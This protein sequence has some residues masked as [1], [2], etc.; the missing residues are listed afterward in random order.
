M[1]LPIEY[2]VGIRIA[3]QFAPQTA[4]ITSKPLATSSNL[5]AT[6]PA[7]AAC[8]PWTESVTAGSLTGLGL[9]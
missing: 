8:S 3:Q 6:S 9:A 2:R 4:A 7:S 5:T 1:P